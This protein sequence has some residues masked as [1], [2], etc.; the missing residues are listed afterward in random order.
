[1]NIIRGKIREELLAWGG[2]FLKFLQFII[3]VLDMI[4]SLRIII[5]FSVFFNHRFMFFLTMIVRLLVQG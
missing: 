3:K 2:L 5:S 1:M 4:P